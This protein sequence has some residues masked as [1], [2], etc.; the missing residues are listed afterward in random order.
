MINP[1]STLKL[2]DSVGSFKAYSSSAWKSS[3]S[4]YGYVGYGFN[5]QGEGVRR[6]QRFLHSLCYFVSASNIGLFDCGEVDGIWGPKT[7]RAVIN[8]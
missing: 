5:A 1:E 8:F 4:Q 7:E 2:S 6:V 3:F